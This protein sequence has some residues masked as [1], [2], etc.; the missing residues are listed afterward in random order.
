MGKCMSSVIDVATE[1]IRLGEL[2]AR[3]VVR[4]PRYQEKVPFRV[5]RVVDGDTVVGI[6]F[7]YSGAKE[8]MTLYLRLANI[9]APELSDR[10]QNAAALVSQGR[11]TQLVYGRIIYVKV[12]GW[13]KYGGRIIGWAE[14]CEVLLAEGLVKPLGPRGQRAAWTDDELRAIC[15]RMR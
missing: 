5:T 3:T 8:A 2:Q 15:Q 14:V 1:D 9:D 11:L 7:P 13:C 10:R 6:M 12:M 4:P